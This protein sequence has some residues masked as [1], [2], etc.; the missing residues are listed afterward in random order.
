MFGNFNESL[1]RTLY[2]LEFWV[3]IFEGEI[4]EV[5]GKK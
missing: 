2:H 1:H 4:R 5:I 3:L